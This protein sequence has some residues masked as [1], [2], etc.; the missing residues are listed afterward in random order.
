MRLC[1]ILAFLLSGNLI[2]QETVFNYSGEIQGDVREVSGVVFIQSMGFLVIGDSGNEPKINVVNYL[3]YL[4]GSIPLPTLVNRDWEE[5]Q[6]D[7][8]GR[9]YL[10]D[11]GNNFSDRDTM[12]IYRLNNLKNHY[13]LGEPLEIDSIRYTY[14]DQW[15][16]M[17]FNEVG[18]F[19]CEAFVVAKDELHLYSKDHSGRNFTKHYILPNAPGTQIATLQDSTQLDAWVT[20]ANLNWGSN[21]LHLCSNNS[22][23]T[24]VDADLN[25]PFT[26]YDFPTTQVE[27]VHQLGDGAFVFVE[28]V[29]GAGALSKL[30]SMRLASSD[31]N[32]TL[33]PNPANKHLQITVNQSIQRLYVVD[34]TG[35]VLFERAFNTPVP[36]YIIDVSGWAEGRYVAVISIDGGE[37]VEPFVVVR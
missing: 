19:D 11:I 5:M 22:M 2:A 3:G 18:N 6:L 23:T 15:P 14:S 31:N 8:Q 13:L 1:W 36:D 29:E 37:V 26:T 12:V 34:Q 33:F 16:S 21:L 32:L 27:G 35:K 9:V 7:L 24:F 4:E 30:Y 20:G 25:Q 28:D 17:P 10:G